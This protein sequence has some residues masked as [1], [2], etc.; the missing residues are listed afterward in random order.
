M[1]GYS[2]EVESPARVSSKWRALQSGNRAFVQPMQKFLEGEMKNILRER[3][4]LE[5]KRLDL[6]AC[7]NRLRKARSMSAQQNSKEGVDPV[8]VI[9][10]AERE[11]SV[12]QLDFDKQTEIV[13]LLL[14][15]ISSF[16]ATQIRSLNDLVEAQLRYHS[17]CQRLLEDLVQELNTVHG[18]HPCASGSNLSVGD[19][20]GGLGIRSTD[21]D[22]DSAPIFKGTT[23]EN[24]DDKEIDLS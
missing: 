12:A 24:E 17:Q 20:V 8:Q 5:S 23:V 14:E 2:F 10:E 13:K 22:F 11:L 16:H 6:D 19:L 18:F 1:Q 4:I 9:A 3:K 7:K 21:D 15:G